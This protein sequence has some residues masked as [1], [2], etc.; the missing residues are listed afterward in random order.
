M[1]VDSPVLSAGLAIG[2]GI[3]A[4]ILLFVPFVA[5]AYRRRGRLSFW[6]FATWAFALIYFWAIWTYTL[7]PIPDGPIEHCAPM[8]TNPTELITEVQKALDGAGNPLLHPAMLQLALNVLL[9]V[10]LGFFIRVLA[11][12]G[13]AI[14]TLTGFALSMLVELTQLTGVWGIYE[15]AYRMFDVVDL[16]TNT[17]GALVGSIIAL[18]VPFRWRGGEPLATASLPRPVKRGRRVLAMLC[19]WLAFTLFVVFVSAAMQIA[20]RL[21]FGEN[22]TIAPGGPADALATIIPS[23]VWLIVTLASGASIGDLAVQLRYAGGTQPEALARSLRW[24]GGIAGIS[25][26]WLIPV[27]GPI[28]AFGLVVIAIITVFT[29]KNGRGLPGL[30]TGRELTDAR[31]AAATA[32]GEARVTAD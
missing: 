21:L 8:N 23:G 15:C 28:T 25:T 31:A 9:F 19:D 20:A 11:N 4:G 16:M 30:L 14:A 26:I 12:R 24:V 29:T 27:F 17:L 22:V 7:L 2:A 5:L 10:P 18:M 1:H 3:F 13:W 32:E 6:R